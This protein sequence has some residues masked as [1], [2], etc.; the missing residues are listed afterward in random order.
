MSYD[1]ITGLARFA[2][3]ESFSVESG[4]AGKYAWDRSFLHQEE[5]GI[6]SMNLPQEAGMI[7]SIQKNMLGLFFGRIILL[8][9]FLMALVIVMFPYPELPA[10]RRTHSV[11]SISPGITVPSAI[12]N[13]GNG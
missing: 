8:A 3:K 4:S 5:T 11:M 6:C 7:V 2:E 13:L 12:L 9:R 10:A 1:G